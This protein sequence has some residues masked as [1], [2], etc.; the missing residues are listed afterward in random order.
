MLSVSSA[1]TPSKPSTTRRPT[2]A[3]AALAVAARTRK[4]KA[5]RMRKCLVITERS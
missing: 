4:S 5:V 3:V 2:G 1:S